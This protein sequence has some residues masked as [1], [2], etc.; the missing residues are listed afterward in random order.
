[1][2]LPWCFLTLVLTVVAGSLLLAA[3]GDGEEEL[4]LDEYFR[5]LDGIEEGIKTGIA[6][7]EVESEG[8]LGE[9]VEATRAY[10]DGYQDIVGKAVNDMKDL[11]PPAEVGDAHEEF[12]AALSGMLPAWGHL[13]E[14]LAD[15]ETASGVQELL[16]DAGSE[17][18]WQEASQRFADACSEL[19]GI[20]REKGIEVELDCE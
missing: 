19:Q 8:I 6:G 15:V 3:C 16:V 17:P 11:D 18:A 4:G 10:V 7:L 2:K 5:Q 14:R 1:M 13:S 12:V 9:D 20:A